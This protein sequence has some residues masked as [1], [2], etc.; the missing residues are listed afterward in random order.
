MEEEKAVYDRLV[1]RIG[2]ADQGALSEL[3]ERIKTPVYGLALAILRD[4]CDAEDVMQSTFI[5]VWD[6][7]G[8]YRPG[9]DARAWILKIAKNLA[10]GQLR[11]RKRAGTVSLD[12][13]AE[14][15]EPDAI[16]PMLDR[17][18]LDTLLATLDDSERQ[19]VLLH[20]TGG[21]TH[22]EIAAVLG[23]PAATIRWKYS[24]A[25][26]K[27]SGEAAQEQSREE[28]ALRLMPGIV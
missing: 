3:Y 6:C 23:R 14:A 26:R 1:R 20:A 22:Q 24:Q 21:Y 11:S 15:A 19:I 8:Q 5:R 4:P 18:L 9:T 27:L 7:A 12:A 2:A 28:T 10:L 25:L 16:T 13:V 17:V